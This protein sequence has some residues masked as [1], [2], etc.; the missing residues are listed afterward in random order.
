MITYTRVI[1]ALQRKFV[2]ILS[3]ISRNIGFTA[4]VS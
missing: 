4:K 2:S 3:S 1:P